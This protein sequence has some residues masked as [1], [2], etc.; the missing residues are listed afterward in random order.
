MRRRSRRRQRR[1]SLS[2]LP[3]TA[4][5][6]ASRQHCDGSCCSADACANRTSSPCTAYSDENHADTSR[7]SSPARARTTDTTTDADHHPAASD[8]ASTRTSSTNTICIGC[9][10]PLA[11]PGYSKHRGGQPLVRH[12][13]AQEEVRALFC[14][15]GMSGAGRQHATDTSVRCQRL[16]TPFGHRC[17]PVAGLLRRMRERGSS[18]ER[19]QRLG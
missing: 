2:D 13:R 4:I 9:R 14:V 17:P 1:R 11:T 8:Q 7:R 10:G 19:R 16:D 12:S 15:W 6:L 5:D 18:L 3:I